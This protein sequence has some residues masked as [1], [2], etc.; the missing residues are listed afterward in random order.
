M[1]CSRNFRVNRRDDSLSAA[2]H[3]REAVGGYRNRRLGCTPMDGG[4]RA[5][6]MREGG[7]VR[8]LQALRV[9]DFH[10]V[11]GE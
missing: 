8:G 3:L 6:G 5:A 11:A 2:R 4:Y 1:S 10:L 9:N 7:D